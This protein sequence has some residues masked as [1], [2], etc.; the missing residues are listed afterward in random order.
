MF[1]VLCSLWYGY[2]PY[3]GAVFEDNQGAVQ[4]AQHPMTNSNSKNI[5]VR[6]PTFV[7]GLLLK[8]EIRV[9]CVRS[10]YEQHAD[11]LT[12]PLS[13]ERHFSFAVIF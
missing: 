10:E 8:G 6:A 13:T 7:G 4:L 12:K 9:I 11:F 2:M 5:D 3:C 1:G